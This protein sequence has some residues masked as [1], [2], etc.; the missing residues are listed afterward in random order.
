[1]SVAP[2][3]A[4]SFLKQLTGE[5]PTVCRNMTPLC[6]HCVGVGEAEMSTITAQERKAVEMLIDLEVTAKMAHYFSKLVTA[7]TIL[8]T[9]WVKI[10]VEIS[11]EILVEI[12]VD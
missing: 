6:Q 5:L 1:M 10:S 8:A 3:N 9:I 4:S 11:V 2:P 12:L 7:T